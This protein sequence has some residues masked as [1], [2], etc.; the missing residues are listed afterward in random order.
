M[1]ALLRQSLLCLLCGQEAGHL[2]ARAEA[3]LVQ[4]LVPRGGEPRL[5]TP[6]TRLPRC[7]ACG[8]SVYP[9]EVEAIT[10]WPRVRFGHEKPGRKPRAASDRARVVAS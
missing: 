6:L 8:G 10:L 2:E 9:D 5:V 7:G 1:N 4:R 3:P